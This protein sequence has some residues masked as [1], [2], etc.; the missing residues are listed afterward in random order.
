MADDEMMPD[1]EGSDEVTPPRQVT[2]VHLPRM[3]RSAPVRRVEVALATQAEA[4][5]NH[6]KQLVKLAFQSS[7]GSWIFK[8][9]LAGAIG[10]LGFTAMKLWSG[11]EMATTFRLQIEYQGKAIEK[12][13]LANAK[14]QGEID[15]LRYHTTG[16]P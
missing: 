4:I 13:E 15:A 14:L 16:Q 2:P 8:A 11:S 6:D 10:A 7:I 1:D 5:S 12:L 9:F 3:D